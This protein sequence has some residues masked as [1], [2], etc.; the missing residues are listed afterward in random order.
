MP[1]TGRENQRWLCGISKRAGGL[2]KKRCSTVGQAVGVVAVSLL[3]A[4]VGAAVAVLAG[5]AVLVAVAVGDGVVVGSGVG[6]GRETAVGWVVGVM[7]S[8][9]LVAVGSGVGDR[10]GDGVAVVCWAIGVA[11]MA[12][13]GGGSLRLR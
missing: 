11:W 9:T 8:G 1:F 2:T 6:E 10:V 7:G 3:G 13:E 12:I 5:V 4:F